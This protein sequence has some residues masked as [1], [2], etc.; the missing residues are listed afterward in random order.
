MIE[1]DQNL[2]LLGLDAADSEDVIR[3][4]CGLLEAQGYTGP[5][6]CDDVLK[7]E[8]E[9]PTG[10]PSEGVAAA[11]PHAFSADVRRTGTALAVLAKPVAFRDI[12]DY[13]ATLQVRLVFVLANAQG[14][15]EHLDTLQELMGCMSRPQLLLDLCGA[16][17]PAQA[18]EILRRAE[19]YPEE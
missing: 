1:T 8:A 6:Y 12:S 16:K 18:A 5:H 19:D 15:G 9:Y 17:T 10:L 7:R 11:I 2:I 3:R 14:A 4:L 13:D